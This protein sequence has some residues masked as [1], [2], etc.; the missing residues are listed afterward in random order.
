VK[1]PLDTDL[2]LPH[3]LSRDDAVARL[4]ELLP[5]DDA[6]RVWDEIIGPLYDARQMRLGWRNGHCIRCGVPHPESQ[7][8]TSTRPWPG[9]RMTCRK[10]VGPLE[11]RI[12][13][14][15]QAL[16]GWN[17]D[18]S[19]GR[20]YLDDVWAEPRQTCPDAA[21]DWRGPRPEDVTL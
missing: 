12:V 10:Y 17:S 11:H 9:H 20:S 8:V 15:H 13:N 3:V 21:L 5:A 2:H 4:L 16:M 19:C 1:P 18:C 6:D 14:G 7:R